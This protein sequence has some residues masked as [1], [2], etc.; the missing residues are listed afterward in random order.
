MREQII[1]V[2][3]TIALAVFFWTNY[4]NDTS[5]SLNNKES[6]LTSRINRFEKRE[7]IQ[8]LDATVGTKAFHP[9]RTDDTTS[10]KYDYL[11]TLTKVSELEKKLIKLGYFIPP[12]YV[13]LY[14][15]YTEE[16]LLQMADHGD[17][18]AISALKNKYSNSEQWN[19]LRNMQEKAVVH[20]SISDISDLHISELSMYSGQDSR[21]KL[22]KSA[23]YAELAGLR[24]SKVTV[25][26]AIENFNQNNIKFT[27]SELSTIND[28]AKEM[29]DKINI[30]RQNNGKNV[31]EKIDDSRLINE[32]PNNS[33]SGWGQNFIA[34]NH[35]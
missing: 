33:L 3:G 20:G 13:A 24:G 25:Y 29:L 1:L 11:E 23:A 15:S 34:S 22:I 12:D 10:Y 28:M 5:N 18:V 27:E 4:E 21:E 14:D 32:A 17:M 2:L 16:A 6:Q 26:Y 31:L 9:T 30:A 8:V 35:D 7:K 19:L